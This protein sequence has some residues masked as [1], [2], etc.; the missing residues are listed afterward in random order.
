MNS[1]DTKNDIISIE[2]ECDD[3]IQARHKYLY[4]YNN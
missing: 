4:K 3:S 2:Y 1:P